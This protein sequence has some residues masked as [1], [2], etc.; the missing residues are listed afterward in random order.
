[1]TIWDIWGF[2]YHPGVSEQNYEQKRG[3][4]TRLQA[5]SQVSVTNFVPGPDYG[6]AA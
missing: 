2:L 6:K 5:C 1:M 3:K 4:R